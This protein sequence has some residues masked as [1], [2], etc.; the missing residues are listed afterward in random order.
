MSFHSSGIIKFNILKNSGVDT[1]FSEYATLGLEGGAQN[2]SFGRD[3][4]SNETEY[5]ENEVLRS[6]HIEQN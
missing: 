2:D 5:G 6:K 3:E 4:V 1:S